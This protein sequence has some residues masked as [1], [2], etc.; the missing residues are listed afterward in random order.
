VQTPVADHESPPTPAERRVLVQRVKAVGVDTKLARMI[1]EALVLELGSHRGVRVVSPAE[2]EQTVSFARDQAT[3]GCDV[4]DAC[5]I[6][7]RRKLQVRE[8]V[9]GKVS[10]LGKELVVTLAL[11]DMHSAEVSRRVTRQASGFDT[12]RAALSG[13]G[14]ELL[15]TAGRVAAF[16]LTPGTMLKLAVM[17][18]TP[19]GVPVAT[20]SAMTQILAAELNQIEGVRVISS[21]DIAALLSKVQTEGEL[22]CTDNMQCIVEIGASLGLSKLVSGT[23]GKIDDTYVISAQLID[24]RKAEVENR[25][26]EAFAGDATELSSA[27]KL[28]AYRLAGVD[29]SKRSGGVDFTFNVDQAQVRLG[30]KQAQATDS[31]VKF[32]RLAPGRYS[33]RVLA[34]RDR[35]APL[36]TDIYVA[37]GVANVRTFSLLERPVALYER[38]W[39]WTA[40]GVAAA[41][42]TALAIALSPNDPTTGSGSVTIQ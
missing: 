19:R 31:R 30:Q 17:P 23:V 6:E 20:A 37:P 7:V 41:G 26:L 42:G 15:G 28:T 21:D 11:I 1:E 16:K 4:L 40:I 35:Y 10:K 29:Y 8:L 18:L 24:T 39:F 36:Q 22:G 3:L 25:V 13:A 9:S 14:D 38:W 27:V 33:L 5:M 32:E 2:L 12:L 34:D